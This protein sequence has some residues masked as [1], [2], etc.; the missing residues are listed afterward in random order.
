MEEEV[1][2][3]TTRRGGW[4]NGTYEPPGGYD[5]FLITTTPSVD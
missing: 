4:N 2:I 3:A 5:A 1:P